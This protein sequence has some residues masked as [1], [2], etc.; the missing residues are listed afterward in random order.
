MKSESDRI[1][2]ISRQRHMEKLEREH[3]ARWFVNDRK[4]EMSNSVLDDL[5]RKCTPFPCRE[6]EDS[7]SISLL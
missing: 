6:P 2:I 3:H 1:A 4:G 5:N 7:S